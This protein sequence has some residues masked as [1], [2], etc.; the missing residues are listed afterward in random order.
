[1]GSSMSDDRL[2]GEKI[3]AA[4]TLALCAAG[5]GASHSQRRDALEEKLVFLMLLDARLFNRESP[6]FKFAVICLTIVQVC[7]ALPYPLLVIPLILLYKKTLVQIC[8][9][10]FCSKKN[11]CLDISIALCGTWCFFFSYGSIY[12]TRGSNHLFHKTTLSVKWLILLLPTA[13]H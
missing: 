2:S 7:N 10:I 12:S 8:V 3:V 5:T 13:L 11:M 6:T 1:M 4:G 9:W